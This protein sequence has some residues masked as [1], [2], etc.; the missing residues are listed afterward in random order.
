MFGM[1]AVLDMD[2]VTG[3]ICCRDDRADRYGYVQQSSIDIPGI[4]PFRLGLEKHAKAFEIR[5][6]HTTPIASRPLCEVKRRRA[7]LVLRWGTTWEA[8]V[9]FLF[10]FRQRSWPHTT[11]SNIYLHHP[12]PLRLVFIHTSQLR[13]VIQCSHVIPAAAAYRGVGT[14]VCAYM[15]IDCG[16]G[17]PKQKRK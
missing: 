17:G 6:V 16:L 14:T 11:Y 7:G 15:P 10:C 3:I 8:L 12:V 2:S 13:T 4:T 5:N 9:L 1:C